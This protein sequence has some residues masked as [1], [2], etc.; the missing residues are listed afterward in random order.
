MVDKGLVLQAGLVLQVDLGG[1]V[2]QDVEEEQ[3]LR[4]DKALLD[5][6]DRLAVQDVWGQWVEQGE[7]GLLEVQV[8]EV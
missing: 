6:V 8:L 5:D 4:V 1:P 3:D 2:A 7:G